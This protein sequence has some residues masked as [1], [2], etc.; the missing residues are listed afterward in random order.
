MTGFRVELFV[1]DLDVFA[2]FYTRVLGFELT[3]RREGCA[4]VRRVAV[5]IGA[6]PAW[7]PVDPLARR[8]PTGVEFVVEVGD[9]A[10]LSAERDRIVGAG[11][12]LE[13]DLRLRP[14]GLAD[15]RLFDP[16]GHYLRFTTT[17]A[18][19]ALAAATTSDAA[20]DAAS[21]SEDGPAVERLA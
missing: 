19:T 3:E 8:V 20:S 1:A 2:D 17:G 16:D 10:D 6:V 13:A 14:W 7:S 9:L 5:R 4:A 18:A 15:F 21:A 12:A 11:G